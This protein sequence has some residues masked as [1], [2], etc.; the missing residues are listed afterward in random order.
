MMPNSAI[1]LDKVRTPITK[2]D[3]HWLPVGA[4]PIHN[5]DSPELAALIKRLTKANRKRRGNRAA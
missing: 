5:P 1:D 4:K 3:M 2:H